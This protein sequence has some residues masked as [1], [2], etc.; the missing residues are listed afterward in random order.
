[1]SKINQLLQKI[2]MHVLHL[3]KPTVPQRNIEKLCKAGK[4]TRHLCSWVQ[5]LYVKDNRLWIINN[6]FNCVEKMKRQ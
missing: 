6:S 2:V 3:G 4:N 1:M 5:N